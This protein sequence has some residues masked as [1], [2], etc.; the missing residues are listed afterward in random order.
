MAR[1]LVDAQLEP[2]LRETDVPA[3]LEVELLASDAP[4]PA[5]DYAGMIPL[6]T[7]T[8]GPAELDGLPELRVVAN[9]AVG[10]DNI[11]VAAAQARDVAVSNTPGV[12]T[13]ATAE[14]TWTLILAASRRVREGVELARSGTWTGWGPT[15]LLGMELRGK[16]LGL[17]GAG[18][19]GREVGLRAPAFG[20]RV[21]CWDRTPDPD[22]LAR[23]GAAAVELGALLERSDVISVHV[24][25]TPETEHLLDAAA[26]ARVKRGAVLVNTA[27]GPIVDESA[28]IDALEGGRLRAAGLDVYEREPEIPERLRRLD[29]VVVLPHLGSATDEARRGMWRLAWENLLRGLR[30]EPLLTPVAGG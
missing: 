16:V 19:I 28:L 14:L 6:L 13:V 15:Q 5:G 18:R 17:I 4:T 10:Y 26:L 30:G 8:V 7:R 21:L 9:Y 12:L 20:M 1:V 11:D 29:N 27:R 2:F 24:P 3:E 25:L 22:W 23:T